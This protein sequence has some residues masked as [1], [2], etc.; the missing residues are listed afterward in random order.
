MG[1]PDSNNEQNGNSE[2]LPACFLE[3]A[4][5]QKRGDIP[6]QEVAVMKVW[7]F[8]AERDKEP[9]PWLEAVEKATEFEAAFDW[10]GA[11]AAYRHA[12]QVAEN[13]SLQSKA[14]NHLSSLYSLLGND[15]PAMEAAKAATQAARRAEI[16]MV[17]SPMLQAEA[18]LYLDKNQLQQAWATLDESL[19]V[20]EDNPMAGVLRA[21]ALILR[22][23]C[24]IREGNLAR[25]EEELASAWK[26]LESHV[27]AHFAG[28]W[29]SRLAS[30]WTA[31]ARLHVL[32]GKSELAV[33]AWR[34]AVARRR[35]VADLPQIG[36]PYKH[37]AVAVALCNSAKFL[38]TIEDDSAGKLFEESDAIR[39]SIGLPAL[40]H[41]SGHI[42]LLRHRSD[43]K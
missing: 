9:S 13:P 4:D 16:P 34:E 26:L 7:Q 22:A 23:D 8:V 41:N 43:D 39:Q 14:Y 17:L 24:F 33:L 31:T 40:D 18:Q 1:I 3:Y 37:N 10:Q 38:Q 11:E 29:Q 30:W 42:D 27:E 36:G 20:I 28:G 32:Q 5:A 12:I 35:I 15:G 25:A 6:A 21:K 2:E 19:A